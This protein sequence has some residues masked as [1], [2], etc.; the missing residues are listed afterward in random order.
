GCLETWVSGPALTR[1]HEAATGRRW[2]PA[3]I[4][5]AADAG[6]EGAEAAL[7]RYEGRLARGLA[8]VINVIDPAAIVLGGGLSKLGRL[9]ERV[10]PLLEPLVFSDR[11]AARLL[12]PLHGD[13]S[14][15]RGAAWLWP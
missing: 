13:S 9:Y 2:T 12:P 6:D 5:R 7:T 15:V 8:V 11:L 10:P 1:D 14:G 4:A 3:E